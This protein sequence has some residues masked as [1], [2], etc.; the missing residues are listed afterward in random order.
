M[1]FKHL[2]LYQFIEDFDFNLENLEPQLQSLSFKPCASI[3]PMSVGWQAPVGQSETAPLI[4]SANGIYLIALRIEEK[5]LPN[6]VIRDQLQ[7]KVSEIQTEQ[8]RKL[9][10]KEKASL[11][12]DIYS[13]LLPRAF[14]KNSII[15]AMI[16]PKQKQLMIDTSSRG[17]AEE[18]ITFLRKSVGSLPVA[19]LETANPSLIMTK[20]LK[21]Q[22]SPKQFEIAESCLLHDS[23]VDGATIRCSKQDLLSENIQAFI[24]D[25]MEVNQLQLQWKQHLTFTLRDDFSIT[26]IKYTDAVQD[27]AADIHTE[28]AEQQLDASFFIMSQTIGEFLAELL[29]LF[30]KE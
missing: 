30:I 15:L 24:K 13:S 7:E 8:N 9:S 4:H 18:F 17:K 5:I 22:Q 27:L 2:Q 16:D 12:D 23:K 21:T 3:L 11:K 1:W 14:S 29:P 26:Q 20:W 6:T 28:T 19:P 10:S 25:G